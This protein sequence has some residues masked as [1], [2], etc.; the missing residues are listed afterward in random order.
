M[1]PGHPGPLPR[2]LISHTRQRLAQ[3][4][5]WLSV[6]LPR[7]K[8]SCAAAPL[9][10]SAAAT[11]HLKADDRPCETSERPGLAKREEQTPAPHLG[12]ARTEAI[13]PSHDSRLTVSPQ[14]R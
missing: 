11:I 14:T 10:A 1:G 5:P 13:T 9:S 3:L 12:A 2:R 4:R 6:S 7:A 8:K